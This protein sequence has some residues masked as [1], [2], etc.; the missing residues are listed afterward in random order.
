MFLNIN[1]N[2]RLSRTQYTLFSSFL[3]FRNLK[4]KLIVVNAVIIKNIYELNTNLG[5]SIM[6]RT[7][8]QNENTF[9]FKY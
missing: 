2:G 9:D 6:N 1:W 8:I 4:K 5:K 3:T 7:D